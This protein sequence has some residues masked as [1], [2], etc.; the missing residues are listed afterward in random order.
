MLT[1]TGFKS[2]IGFV[3][4]IQTSTPTHHAAIA[5]AIAQGFD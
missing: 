5:M 3:D 2:T 1:L 4:D